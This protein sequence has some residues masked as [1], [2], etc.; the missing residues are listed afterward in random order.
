MKTRLL[1]IAGLLLMSFQ[2]KARHAKCDFQNR[3]WCAYDRIFGW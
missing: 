3:E 1:I 2:L